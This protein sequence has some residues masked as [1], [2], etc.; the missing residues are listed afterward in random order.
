M[1]AEQLRKS[2]GCQVR[3]DKGASSRS[4]AAAKD[5]L[6]RATL[7]KHPV[8]PCQASKSTALRRTWC[9]LPPPHLEAKQPVLLL[10]CLLHVDTCS[11]LTSCS[12]VLPRAS[13]ATCSYP[14]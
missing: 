13:P 4:E 12:L 3:D 10:L 1:P 8:A 7:H 11:L 5:W 14:C 6:L 9:A 2:P